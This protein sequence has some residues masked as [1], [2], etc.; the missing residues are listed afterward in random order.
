[1]LNCTHPISDVVSD[2][3]PYRLL[4]SADNVTDTT[5]IDVRLWLKRAVEQGSA[6]SV[7]AVF[8]MNVSAGEAHRYELLI[9]TALLGAGEYRGEILLICGEAEY[10]EPVAFFRIPAPLD[11]PFPFAI[12]AVP[13]IEDRAAWDTEMEAVRA[14]G[15][16][17]I[18]QHMGSV[19][20]FLPYLDRAARRGLR[21]M[22]S[23]NLHNAG[24]VAEE[25]LQARMN[26]PESEPTQ[27]ALCFN[28]PVVRAHAVAT[29]TDHLR[30]YLAHAGFS[31]LIYYGDDLFMQHRYIG[32]K[33]GLSC[34]CDYCRQD[35]QAHNGQPPPLATPSRAGVV[36]ADDPWLRWMRYRSGEVFGG[37][38]GALEA[39]RERIAPHAR[40]G[41]CHGFPQQPFSSLAAGIYGPLSQPTA[42]VSS[43]AYPYLRSPRAD[44]ICHYEIGKMGN[45]EKDIWMLGA[46]SSNYTLYPA[47]QVYQQ[48]WNMLAAGYKFIGFFSWWDMAKSLEIGEQARVDEEIAA[49]TRCGAHK[50]WI[51]PA[52][53]YW[54]TPPAPFALLY[55]FTTEAFDLDPVNRGYLHT[56]RILAVQRAALRRQ[57]PLEIISEE[58]ILDGILEHYQAV[59]LCDVRAVPDTVHRA[60]EE[61]IARGGTVL[62]ESELHSFYFG[63]PQISI[64]GAYELSAEAITAVLRD[65]CIP[66][67]TLSGEDITLRGHQSGDVSYFVLVNN[68]PDR[69]WGHHFRYDSPDENYRHAALV[70]SESVET[71][72][73]FA[74]GGRW[75]YDLSTGALLGTTDTPLTLRLEPAWGQ[76]LAALSC[77]SATLC[78]TGDTVVSQGQSA[79][80]RLE[81]RDP[82]DQRIDGA[83][84]VKVILV[85]PTG[86]C[87]RAGE[88]LGLAAGQADIALP[89]ALDDETG[90]W[91]VIF[92]GGLP[93]VARTTCLR[94]LP[95]ET[96]NKLLSVRKE[97]NI[98]RRP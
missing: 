27:P 77:P 21:F 44:L 87:V 91:Q 20:E 5:E 8:R 25:A 40:M 52:V 55:S 42:V 83:F 29:F 86:H 34:Y 56:E 93:R 58:E 68:Y 69:Y 67:A 94:V 71:T 64:N 54:R 51:L 60:L 37:F 50:D 90:D 48:Y 4:V 12:Y 28:Q 30:G 26:M 74:Q 17:I 98:E 81:M 95:G 35:F 41:M 38:I 36:P 80:L 70:R 39:E 78:V 73:T 85:S 46:F 43:Y 16:N 10:R 18:C 24:V 75:L 49:L 59:C 62:K 84:T 82:A 7:T 14:T 96:A 57:V 1:M 72:M 32:E 92:A 66:P 97:Q 53:K 13:W 6:H 19:D 9:D 88:Y 45:R 11:T 79:R 63:Y 61:Y 47:W 2:T 65:R 15:I 76:V 89:I 33:I 23:D 3:H 31:G 22:P